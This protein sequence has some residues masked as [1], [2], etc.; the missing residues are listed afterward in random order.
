MLRS[1]LTE[2]SRDEPVAECHETEAA[3]AEEA[4]LAAV[5]SGD[6]LCRCMLFKLIPDVVTS[7]PQ[8]PVGSPLLMVQ[9]DQPF[10]YL[11]EAFSGYSRN[12]LRPPRSLSFS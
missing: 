5:S 2:L 11:G 6:P 3:S 12:L 4:E 7:A 1:L 10:F 9:T 8:P